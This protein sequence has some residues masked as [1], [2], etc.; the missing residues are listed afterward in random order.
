MHYHWDVSNRI[1]PMDSFNMPVGKCP[2][3]NVVRPLGGKSSK[4]DKKIIDEDTYKWDGTNYVYDWAP[5]KRQID[6][7]REKA[8]LYQLTI[9]NPPWAFQRGIDFKGS[10]Q[11]ET[12]GNAWPP[13]DSEAWGRYLRAMLKELVETYGREEVEQWRFCIGREIGTEGHWRA[14]QLEFFEHY[15]NTVNSIHAVLPTAK[16]GTHF[17]WASAKHPFGPD[18]V[19]WCKKNDVHYDFIGVSYYPFY[20]KEKRVDIDY[21]YKVDFA[22]IKGIPQWNRSATLEIHEFALIKSMSARGNSF[23]NA[24]EAHRESFTVMLGKMMYEHDIVDVFR[25]GSGEGRVAEQAF[26]AMKGNDYYASSKRGKPIGSGSMVDAVFS[27][28]VPNQQYNIMIYHYNADL[29]AKTGEP[30]KIATT[31]PVPPST[32]IQY[33]TARYENRGLT[34]SD[35]KMI[36]TTATNGLEKSSLE[37]NFQLTPFSF[38]VVELQLPETATRS[39]S[40]ILIENNAS[41]DS[42]RSLNPIIIDV[43]RHV[44]V[45]VLLERP[46]GCEAEIIPSFLA[47]TGP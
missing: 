9:D 24:P 45:D 5:L 19:K 7:V 31:L 29:H 16:V 15:R 6:T 32:E 23:V 26:F 2:S 1:S 33:R 20:D 3:I 43:P 11:V 12:Y 22:P 46:L 38:Q 28:D 36:P 8:K 18:F 30:V 42:T 47:R 34:W 41:S 21:V 17:L 44:A 25:W 13:N 10:K 40:S 37:L 39:S 35:W 4:G 14:S 27:L